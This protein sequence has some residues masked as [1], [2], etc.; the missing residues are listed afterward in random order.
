MRLVIVALIILVCLFGLV[1]H[2]ANK[3]AE[4][5]ENHFKSIN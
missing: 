2:E 1:V 3:H 4:L 5:R